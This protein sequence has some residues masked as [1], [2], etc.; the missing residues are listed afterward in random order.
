MALTLQS[1]PAALEPMRPY[2]RKAAELGRVSPLTALA[3][4]MFAMQI[5]ITLQHKLP[6]TD[7]QYLLL[8]M[9]ELEAEKRAL[10]VSATGEEQA[11][12]VKKLAARSLSIENLTVSILTLL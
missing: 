3:L 4:R 2:L 12:A 1:L 9:D 8:L 5:G 7:M 10:G 11:A 6:P